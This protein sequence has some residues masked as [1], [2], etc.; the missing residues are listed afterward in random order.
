MGRYFANRKAKKSRKS[1]YDTA[2]TARLWQVS[3]DL[4]G[5]PADARHRPE[6]RHTDENRRTPGQLRL[7]RRPGVDRT[8][9]GQGR[10]RRR[11]RRIASSSCDRVKTRPGWRATAVQNQ[12]ADLLVGQLLEPPAKERELPPAVGRLASPGVRS[13]PSSPLAAPFWEEKDATVA[14]FPPAYERRTKTVSA[15]RSTA[16]CVRVRDEVWGTGRTEEPEPLSSG[17]P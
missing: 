2:T 10:L 3:A 8:D 16:I 13:S 17:P 4:V 14:G 6:G 7:P 15:E 11:G 12:R 5:L 1:S 9:A